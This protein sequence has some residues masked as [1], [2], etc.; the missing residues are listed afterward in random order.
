LGVVFD[1]STEMIHKEGTNMAIGTDG[2]GRARAWILVRVESPHAVAQQLYEELGYEGGE[3]WVLVRAD[4]VDYHY[5]IVVPVDAESWD[6]LEGVVGQIKELTGAED[7][8]VLPVVEHIPTP[9]HLAHGYVTDEEAEAGG[10]DT[11]TGRLGNSPGH[12]CWG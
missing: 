1:N 4:V 6:V 7:T 3:S 12:N 5:N 9:P 11:E 8:V 2:N 10:I